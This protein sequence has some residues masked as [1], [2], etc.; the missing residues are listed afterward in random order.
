VLIDAGK[1]SDALNLGQQPDAWRL[2]LDLGQAG[3]V[4]IGGTACV[5]GLQVEPLQCDL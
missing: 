5:V 2:G 1:R 4:H 3:M